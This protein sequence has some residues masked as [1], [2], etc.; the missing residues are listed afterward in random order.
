MNKNANYM[1][2]LR[3]NRILRGECIRCGKKLK[4]S[5]GKNCLKCCQYMNKYKKTGKIDTTNTTYYYNRMAHKNKVTKPILNNL[6]VEEK[7]SIKELAN[8]T[9]ITTRTISR[10]LFT[11]ENYSKLTKERINN[12]FGKNVL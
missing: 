9:G 8:E 3:A 2:T 12:Y 10:L 5:E 11:N 6:I 4:S 7:L 1:K